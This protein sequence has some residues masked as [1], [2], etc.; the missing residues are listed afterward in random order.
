[1]KKFVFI[2]V[3]IVLAAG[4]IFALADNTAVPVM[5]EGT[6][7]QLVPPQNLRW[8]D[9]GNNILTWSAPAE[10][11]S[12][13]I[14]ANDLLQ[15]STTST[16]FDLVA[17]SLPA[18]MHYI[19]IRAVG[20]GGS[21]MD[22]ERS[23]AFEF[24]VHNASNNSGEFPSWAIGMMAG[25]TSLVVIFGIVFFLGLKARQESHTKA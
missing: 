22:S 14:Y 1:V 5:A 9:E 8:E 2:L 19:T 15:A 6:G 18:G 3:M 25:F 21:I 17:L 7:E 11:T 23:A 16:S 12:F 20:D 10:A 4:G 24:T 13:R